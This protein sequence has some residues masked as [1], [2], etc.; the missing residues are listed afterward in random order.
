MTHTFEKASAETLDKINS[1]ETIEL[2]Q[3]LTYVFDNQKISG[4]MLHA[5]DLQTMCIDH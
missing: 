2:A 5:Y 3:L 1:K 4:F